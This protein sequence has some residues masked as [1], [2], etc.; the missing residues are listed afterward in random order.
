MSA[1]GFQQNQ[2]LI[3]LDQQEDERRIPGW[4]DMDHE[5]GRRIDARSDLIFV[6]EASRVDVS[7]VTT[8]IRNASKNTIYLSSALKEPQ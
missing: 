5:Y 8:G 3:D 7:A 6:F 2:E 1:T 4:G